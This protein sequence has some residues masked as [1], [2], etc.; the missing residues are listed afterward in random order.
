VWRRSTKVLVVLFVGG[1]VVLFLLGTS[2][3]LVVRC[4]YVCS[5][6]CLFTVFG[7][8]GDRCRNIYK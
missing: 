4:T 6:C 5:A 2:G 7:I 1:S 8:V 3:S